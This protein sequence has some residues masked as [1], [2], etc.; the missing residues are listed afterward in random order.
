M[1]DTRQLK[2]DLGEQLAKEIDYGVHATL[3]NMFGLKPKVGDFSIQ[4][5]C[6]IRSDVSGIF[7]MTQDKEKSSYNRSNKF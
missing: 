5:E 7:N 4:K 6:E 3:S 2:V 1:S